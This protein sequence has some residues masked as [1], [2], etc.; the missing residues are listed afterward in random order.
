MSNE[1][2][3]QVRIDLLVLYC[4]DLPSCHDFYRN[5]GLVFE[6]ERHG[7]GPEHYAATLA[8]DAVLE[9]YPAGSGAATKRVRVGLTISHS[10]LRAP[11]LTPGSHVLHDPEGR[12]VDLHVIP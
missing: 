6:R 8:A 5:L 4:S 11:L 2:L 10:G 3:P 1:T 7:G 12:T 9:L